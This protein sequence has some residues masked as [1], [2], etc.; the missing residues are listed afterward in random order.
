MQQRKQ[1][2]EL[3][4]TFFNKLLV[5]LDNYF[6]SVLEVQK[7]LALSG[8]PFALGMIAMS[9][10]ASSWLQILGLRKTLNELDGFMIGFSEY[11]AILIGLSIIQFLLIKFLRRRK[12]VLVPSQALRKSWP[13]DLRG[14]DRRLQVGLVKGWMQQDEKLKGELLAL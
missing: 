2:Y 7:S 1:K 13:S 12:Y 14:V 10:I 4:E 9:Y 6:D 11:I 3:K 8:V 5:K